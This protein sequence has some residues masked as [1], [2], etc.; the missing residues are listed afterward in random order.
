MMCLLTESWDCGPL[1]DGHVLHTGNAL[2]F[3]LEFRRGYKGVDALSTMGS[4]VSAC[5]SKARWP[6]SRQ[7][8]FPLA[9][10]FGG[11]DGRV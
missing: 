9:H 6:Q 10:S 11:G 1:A 3:L 4:A 8:C 2:T 5:T 7:R